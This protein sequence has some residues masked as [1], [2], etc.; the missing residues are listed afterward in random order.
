MAT[1]RKR[2][3]S[4]GFSDKEPDP[5]AEEKEI[6]ELLE[7]LAD[8]VIDEIEEVVEEVVTQPQIMPEITPTEDPGPR[9]LEKTPQN[10]AKPQNVAP[11]PVPVPLRPHPRNIP[12]FSRKV[13]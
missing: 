3:T 10:P 9:F 8:E 1:T 7:E 13:K 5:V 12:K 4:S 11:L 2:P 6:S